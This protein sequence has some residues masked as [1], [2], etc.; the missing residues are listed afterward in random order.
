MK[1]RHVLA[2][3]TVGAASIIGTA[4]MA[5]AQT[6][7]TNPAPA[8]SAQ[9]KQARCEKATARLPQIQARITKVDARITLLRTKL[10]NVQDQPDRVK[11]IQARIDWSQKVHD[12][13]VDIT[14][15]INTRCGT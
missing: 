5:V 8:V 7:P 1:A 12:H 9:N 13:L 4:G 15:Q 6:T 14:N 3:L 2:A 11:L 10:A